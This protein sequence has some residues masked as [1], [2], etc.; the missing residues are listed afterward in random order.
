MAGQLHKRLFRDTIN[1]Q[2][3]SATTVDERGI[4]SQAWQSHLSSVVCKIDEGATTEAK[5][6]RNT[7]LQNLTVYFHG[8]VDV[9]ANDRLQSTS[10]STVYYE[11]DSIR[12]S[13]NRSGNVIGVVASAHLFD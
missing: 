8:N 13:K 12:Q 2:R 11:I 3:I 6:D 1:V 4:E 10:D 7:I 5:G 9:K